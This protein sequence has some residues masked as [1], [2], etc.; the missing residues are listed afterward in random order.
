[1][2]WIRTNGTIW[3]IATTVPQNSN[4]FS[5]YFRQRNPYN[6][7]VGIKDAAKIAFHCPHWASV[8]C[9]VF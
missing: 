2:E 3:G 9:S 1:M 7:K 4:L 6:M 8:A 5:G